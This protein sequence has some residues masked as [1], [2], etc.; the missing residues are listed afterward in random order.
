[1]ARVLIADDAMFVR[2]VIHDMLETSR[3]EV[4]GEAASG[5]ETVRLY[6]ELRPD[7]VLI[8]IGMP[9]MNGL[10]AAHVIRQLDP[11]ARIIIAS[12]FVNASRMHEIETVGASYLEK[13]FDTDQLLA[14]IENT[15][16]R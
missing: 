15:P 12:V 9:G 4:V 10:K 8:D 16:P 13:P 6:N 1:M 5:D 2:T 14:A 3:H 7:V 11:T